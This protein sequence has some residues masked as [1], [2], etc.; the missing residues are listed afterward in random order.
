[1]KHTIRILFYLLIALGLAIGPFSAA[2]RAEATTLPNWKVFTVYPT[3]VDDTE[4]IQHAFDQAVAAGPGSTVL[5]APGNFRTR[6][7][8]VWNF[9]GYFK[10]SGQ[11]ATFIDTFANMDCAAWVADGHDQGL[12]RFLYGY[13]RISDLTFQFTVNPPCQ[14]INSWLG[15]GLAAIYTN[16]PRF[17]SAAECNGPNQIIP[18]SLNVERITARGTWNPENGNALSWAVVFGGHEEYNFPE[19]QNVTR[20]ATGTFRVAQSTFD[21]VGGGVGM[22]AVINSRVIVG[23]SPDN[24][25]LFDWIGT[26]MWMND[27]S[28]S[29]LEVSY[30]KLP[31]TF[32]TGYETLQGG[33]WWYPQLQS[34]STFNIHHN[35]FTMIGNV[36]AIHLFDFDNYGGDW[37]PYNQKTIIAN[38][39]HNRFNLSPDYSW[40]VWNE[41]VDDAV[42]HQNTIDG[43][44]DWAMGFGFWGPTRRG[45]IMA[46]DLHGYTSTSAPYKI[47]LGPGTDSYRVTVDEPDSVLDQGTN[48]VINEVPRRNAQALGPAFYTVLQQKLDALQKRAPWRFTGQLKLL[49]P[50]W[51][52][53]YLPVIQH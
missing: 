15:T 53:L 11:D 29:T 12:F 20:F 23:G 30:N 6:F 47:I 5:L 38:I 18:S 43:N 51:N 2:V 9:D 19:C 31:H 32:W 37:W 52:A 46:N 35:E 17:K 50:V 24:G 7:I 33:Y 13:P 39:H 8:E 26:G 45:R 49:S 21:T 42:I 28:G 40:A 10:G 27:L 16:I 4:N 41:W 36:D 48:N 25:N 34:A 44:S 3:G 14:P 22:C 1:M